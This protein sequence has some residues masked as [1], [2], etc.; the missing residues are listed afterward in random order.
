MREGCRAD[1]NQLVKDTLKDYQYME[2]M[3]LGIHLKIIP[4]MRAFNGTEPDLIVDG[5]RFTVRL[6][7]S[8]PL[9]PHPA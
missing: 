8:N 1:R 6:W 9:P 3:G 7:R 2:H 4:L 5:D